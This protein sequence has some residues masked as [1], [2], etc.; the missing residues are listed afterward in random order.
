[1]DVSVNI[2]FLV[3]D[4]G[5]RRVPYL[6]WSVGNWQLDWGWLEDGFNRSYRFV[7]LGK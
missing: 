4:D 5:S 1:M 6:V 7:R 3:V 2:G